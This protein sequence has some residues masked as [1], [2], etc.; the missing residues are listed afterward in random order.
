MHKETSNLHFYNS[1]KEKLNLWIV[2]IETIVIEYDLN[3]VG[4]LVLFLFFLY[5]LFI[6]FSIIKYN[7]IRY[8]IQFEDTDQSE[9]QS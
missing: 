7:T 4:H 5:N 6:D 2:F 1:K 3:R 8:S 9:S